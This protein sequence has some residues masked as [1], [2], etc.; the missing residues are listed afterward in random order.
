MRAAAGREE[1]R[2]AMSR[3]PIR[4]LTCRSGLGVRRGNCRPCDDRHAHA[5]RKGKATWAE[6]ER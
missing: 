6:L 4:C 1:K 2:L 5:V 3:G